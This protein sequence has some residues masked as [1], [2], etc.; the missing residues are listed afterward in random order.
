MLNASGDLPVQRVEV[1]EHFSTELPQQYLPKGSTSF[2]Q[3]GFLIPP[4][5]DGAVLNHMRVAM[6]TSAV[7]VDRQRSLDQLRRMCAAGDE[8]AKSALDAM[9][10]LNLD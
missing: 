9:R 3:T 10:G 1:P 4:N 2:Q 5:V 8:Q 6:C 7:V